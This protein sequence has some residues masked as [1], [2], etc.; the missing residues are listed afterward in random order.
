MRNNKGF[1]LVE[2]IVSFSLLMIAM[3]YLL[4]TIT[5]TIKRENSLLILQEYSVFEANLLNNIY[6]DIDNYV[7]NKNTSDGKVTI[8]ND[9]NKLLI[10]G[11]NKYLEFNQKN[12]CIIYDEVIY[13]LP[14]GVAFDDKVYDLK[15]GIIGENNEYYVAKINLIVNDKKESIKI[16]YQYKNVL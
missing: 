13:E 6:D 16:I 5:I 7:N 3:I 8:S 1:T 12:N 2:V 14:N 9:N 10:E 11:L 15:S 4:S